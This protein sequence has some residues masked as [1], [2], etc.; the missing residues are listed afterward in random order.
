MSLIPT[1]VPLEAWKTSGTPVS[2]TTARRTSRPTVASV[3]LCTVP[4]TLTN[5][6]RSDFPTEPRS[7]VVL[8]RDTTTVSG[9]AERLAPTVR[10]CSRG[11]TF[12]S[13]PNSPVARSTSAPA[14]YTY[15]CTGRETSQRRTDCRV[16]RARVI[17]G[18]SSP[19]TTGAILRVRQAR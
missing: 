1:A 18:G 16:G 14:A 12:P 15:C 5:R 19:V 13:P 8:A 4:T 7:L 17:S 6:P 3:S 10:G 11:S 2:L 9:A